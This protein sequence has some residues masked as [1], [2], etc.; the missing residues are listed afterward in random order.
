MN[1]TPA[2]LEKKLEAIEKK[3]SKV[4]GLVPLVQIDFCDGYFVKSKT[5]ASSGRD[6]SVKKIVAL[7]RKHKLRSE[8]DLMV[9][10]DRPGLRQYR[11]WVEHIKKHEPTRVVF[12]AGSTERW[13]ELFSEMGGLKTQVGLAIHHKHSFS[14]IDKILSGRPFSFL[15]VMGIATVGLSGQ[16]MSPRTPAL[17]KNLRDMYP[18]LPIQVDGGVKIDDA[19]QLQQAGAQTLGVNSGLFKATDIKKQ[20]Q[21]FKDI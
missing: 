15:Q 4:S 2:I 14:E 8:W 13:D 5:Y 10:L 6:D 9:H 11:T 16:Q 12:H 7:V 18:S 1:I 20:I 19:G 21:A 17:I 3:L